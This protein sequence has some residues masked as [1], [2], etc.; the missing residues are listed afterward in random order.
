MVLGF[1][2]LLLVIYLPF[3]LAWVFL[4]L[5]IFCL[6]FNTGPTNTILANVTHASVRASAFALNIFIIH[7]LGDVISPPVIGWRCG[8]SEISRIALA[9]R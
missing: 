1:P 8:A 6:F 5:T 3:P 2:C 7:L 4:F 9:T